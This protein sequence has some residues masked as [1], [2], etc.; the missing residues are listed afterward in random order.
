MAKPLD[1]TDATFA[2][3][4]EKSP[5]PVLVDFW[6]P[7][8]GPCLR[9]APTVEQIAV[10]QSGKLKVVKL[11]VDENPSTA[12]RFQVMSIPT[13]ILFKD[14]AQVERIA[15]AVSKAAIVSQL[16]RHL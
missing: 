8:C 16:Q 5:V 9:L 13:L 11:N 2:E 3:E 7:W 12:T 10:D 4:V 1:V 14:G 6:A 15:V